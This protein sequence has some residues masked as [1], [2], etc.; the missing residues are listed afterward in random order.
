MARYCAHRL[1]DGSYVLDCQ[2]E[3]LDHLTTRFV[4]PLVPVDLAG[5]AMAVLNPRFEIGGGQYQMMTQFSGAISARELGQ[6][7]ASLADHNYAIL[8]AIDMLLG[9]Y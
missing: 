8:R 2:S 5:T 9:G 6:V 4:V 7:V 3:L 1:S